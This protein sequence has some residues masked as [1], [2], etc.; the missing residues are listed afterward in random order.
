M[1]GIGEAA[2]GKVL[3]ALLGL[4]TD[5]FKGTDAQLRRIVPGALATAAEQTSLP[6]GYNGEWVAKKILNDAAAG[7]TTRLEVIGTAGGP[8]ADFEESAIGERLR[9]ALRTELVVDLADVGI[10]V[11]RVVDR[12]GP[13]LVAAVRSGAT[14]SK[15]ALDA[16]ASRFEADALSAILDNVAAAV[17][18]NR[19]DQPTTLDD[20]EHESARRI[21]KRLDVLGLVDQSVVGAVVRSL[22]LVPLPD[23]ED[24]GLFGL[25]AEGGSGKTTLAERMHL[26]SIWLARFDR[27]AP[28]PLYVEAVSE[29][30]IRDEIQRVWGGAP[31]LLIRGVDLVVDGLDEP[32]LERGQAYVA[33]LRSLV[34]DPLSPLRRAVVTARPLDFGLREAEKTY[35]ALLSNEQANAIVA[36]ISAKSTFSVTMTAPLSDAIRRPF[37]AIASGVVLGEDHGQDFATPSRILK[38]VALKAIGPVDGQ[39]FDLLAGSRSVGRSPP[40]VSSALEGCAELHGAGNAEGQPRRCGGCD[41]REDPFSSRVDCRVVRRRASYESRGLRHRARG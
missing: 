29:A 39:S 37:F 6:D 1:T 38:W 24:R 35:L 9:E 17:G 16:M 33:E 18:A 11:H 26:A 7:G 32:G 30:S 28:L 10:D 23:L 41:R 20:M 3:D 15:S 21:R 40:R 13:C 19:E 27:S 12:F 31:N 2:V 8:S 4:I 14:G 22:E 36:M 34:N 5:I 25:V